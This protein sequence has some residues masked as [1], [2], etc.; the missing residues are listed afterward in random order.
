RGQ[1]GRRR[2]V[3]RHRDVGGAQVH[4]VVAGAG[5][6][7]LAGLDQRLVGLGAGAAVDHRRLPGRFWGGRRR[8]GLAPVAAVAGPS[9]ARPAETAALITSRTGTPAAAARRRQSSN[10]GWAPV[11]APSIA[12]SLSRTRP[13]TVSTS[14]TDRASTAR[15]A[16]C[17]RT[18]SVVDPRNSARSTGSRASGATIAAIWIAGRPFFIKIGVDQT[19]SAPAARSSSNSGA[20]SSGL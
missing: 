16:A 5:G 7:R 19:S 18:P 20:T 8:P 13:Y 2:G 14:A 11:T 10:S 17:I 3:Q 15:S 1:H 6:Q 9:S 12:A 4:L